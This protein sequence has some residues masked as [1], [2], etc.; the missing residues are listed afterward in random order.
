[1]PTSGAEASGT[2][3]VE[4]VSDY[5]EIRL[6][7]EDLRSVVKLKDLAVWNRSLQSDLLEISNLFSL[8]PKACVYSVNEPARGSSIACVELKDMDTVWNNRFYFVLPRGVFLEA[9]VYIDDE[10]AQGSSTV[11]V[12]MKCLD[13]AWRRARRLYF[14]LLDL[15]NLHAVDLEGGGAARSAGFHSASV[16]RISDYAEAFKLLLQCKWGTRSGLVDGAY[17]R[18]RIASLYSSP[19]WLCVSWTFGKN[20]PM[21]LC[22]EVVSAYDLTPMDEQGSA[23]TFVELAFDN[24]RYRTAVKEQDLNPV[25]NE[26]FYFNLSDPYNLPEL[27][28]KAYVY[29]VN[30]LFNGSESLVGKVRVEGTSFLPLHDAEVCLYPLQQHR[31]FSFVKGELALKVYTTADTSIRPPNP[32]LPVDTVIC[33]RGVH[34]S[35]NLECV[36]RGQSSR[37]HSIPLQYLKQITKNFSEE[38]ILGQG[39]FGVVYKG[40]LQ[41]GDMIA[42]K[43]I[44]SSLRPGLQKQFENE[45][46][47]LMM[48]KHPNIVRFVGYCYETQNACLEYDRK[49]VFAEMA[50]RL[51]CLEYLPRGSLD[52]YLSDE[53]SGLDW[54][55][56][57]NII[58]G[59]CYG[60]CYLHDQIDKPIIHLDL[61]PANILLDDNMIPK[62]TDFG[63]SRLL[64]QQTICTSSRDGTL[65]YMAPEFLHGG[66][67]TPKS[68]IFSLGVIIME[69][70]T[71]HR[72]YPIVV[73]KASS[74]DFIELTLTKWRNVLQRSLGHRSL[75]TDSEQIK[76]C[77]HVGL[78]CVNPDRTKRPQI[79]EVINMLEEVESTPSIPK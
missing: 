63:L 38:R 12:Q 20:I 36:L 41:N 40:L 79:T 21:W 35:N 78:I 64:D 39:G 75:E 54:N 43:K 73:T 17:S 13:P 19:I 3:G 24:I 65:G 68:D 5:V 47:H 30:R 48:L 70:V 57:Y 31:V 10:P 71:G 58:K 14:D 29:H 7:D 23:S 50:E 46:Y 6:V 59:I 56:R 1:M 67:I 9:C 37:P 77:M 25:W 45:V 53:S 69:V 52:N 18:A 26:R 49:Y 62:V 33:S 22:V 15:S 8:S 44:V 61:K 11:C 27:R 4:F 66:T 60:L 28:L 2:L 74:D 42:V 16:L 32:F 72:D 76:R 51:I 34:V 55:K